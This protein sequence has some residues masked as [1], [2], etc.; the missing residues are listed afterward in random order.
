M[1]IRRLALEHVRGLESAEV[2]FAERGVTVI[3][4]PNETGK[5]TLF[6]ALDVVLNEKHGTTKQHVRA[7]QPH[8]RDVA[9]TIEAELTLGPHHLTI[10]KRFHRDRLTELVVHAPTARQLSGT[11]AHDELRRL[12]EEHTDLALLEALRFRQGRSLDPVALAGSRSLARQLDASAGGPGDP[13]DD[14]LYE[15]I[16]ETYTRYFTER[17]GKE[18]K[19]LTDA[20]AAVERS[21]AEVARLEALEAKLTEAGRRASEVAVQRR[22]L[23]ARRDELAPELAARRDAARRVARLRGE[24]DAARAE[25][26]RAEAERDSAARAVVER[27][28]LAQEV[29][30]AAAAQAEAEAELTRAEDALA[31]LAASLAALDG[32]VA[33]ARD[34]AVRAREQ[35]ERARAIAD[36]VRAREELARALAS[37]RRVDLAIEEAR[38]AEAVLASSAYTEERHRRVRTAAEDVRLAEAQLGAAAPQMIV[39]A[40][41]DVEVDAGDG[42]EALAAG[43]ELERRVPDRRRVRIGDLAEVEVVAGT[44]LE[45]RQQAVRAA[46]EELVSA[47]ADLDVEDADGAEVL[48]EE[49]R[50]HRETIAARDAILARELDGGTR[51]ALETTI[52]GLQDRDAALCERLDIDAGDA[53]DPEAPPDPEALES[54]E[55]K[56]RE[57][58]ASLEAERRARSEE[59]ESLRERVIAARTSRDGARVQHDRRSTRLEQ[60]RTE[61]DDAALAAEVL[62]AEEAVGAAEQDVARCDQALRELDAETV[63]ALVQTAESQLEHAREQLAGLQEEAASLAAVIE[64]H[65]GEGIGEALQAAEAELTRRRGERDGLRRRAEA[66]RTL[67]EAFDRARDEAYAAYRAPLRE[68]IVAAGRMVFGDDLD[69]ELDEELAITSRTLQGITLDFE[70]LSAGAREQ[71]AILTALAAADLAG[72]DGVPLVLDDTLGYTDPGRLERLGAV[73]GRLRG[74]QVVVLTCVAMRFEAIPG[75][76]V[77]RLPPAPVA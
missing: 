57:V 41:R 8:G 60:A 43:A 16:V 38:A 24:C 67:K 6:D 3:E 74:P 40:R 47:C 63:D 7:L 69:I 26:R 53:V 13:H 1:R 68:R 75:A 36:L 59:L 72:E 73:L 15:R 20:D 54:A 25:L 17:S 9:S 70:Q 19:L 46:R 56:A 22:R 37:R 66:A 23:A 30:D 55:S 48:A 18:T 44:S 45:D 50:G 33:T 11:D 28:E 51:D 32:R 4:A 35:H 62:R 61:V 14:A 52:R 76:T 2:H 77:V 39:R 71:L 58:V 34:E 12:L 65:G 49:I 27:E 64:V 29:A 42:P 31:P 10:R 21:E 5:T